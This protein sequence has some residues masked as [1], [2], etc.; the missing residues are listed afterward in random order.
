MCSSLLDLALGVRVRTR[1]TIT[2]RSSIASPL[3]R[4]SMDGGQG[5]CQVPGAGLGREPRAGLA[6]EGEGEGEG[7][8]DNENDVCTSLLEVLRQRADDER[9]LVRAKALQAFGTALSLRW[10]RWVGPI[11]TTNI[12]DDDE[13]YE[14]MC[15]VL[16]YPQHTLDLTYPYFTLPPFPP[17]FCLGL[18]SLWHPG[19]LDHHLTNRLNQLIATTFSHH[20]QSFMM[21]RVC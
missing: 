2:D 8:R 18:P 14:R 9:P 11:N 20:P 1:P 21:R 17:P 13:L 10:P 7:E 4:E 12:T 16:T 5:L 19:G 3:G 6:E 15:H